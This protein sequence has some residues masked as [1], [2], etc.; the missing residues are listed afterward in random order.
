MVFDY[1]LLGL[2]WMAYL[3]IHSALATSR[4]KNWVAHKAPALAPWYRLLYN[5]V[6]LIGLA[7]LWFWMQQLPGSRLW[8]HP[9]LSMLSAAFLLAGGWLGWA[10]FRGYHFGDFAG[11]R[12]TPPGFNEHRTLSTGGLNRYVRHP[13]YSATILL[14]LGWLMIAGNRSTLTA[15]AAILVYLPIGIYWEEQKLL[16]AYGEAYREYARKVKKVIP[17]VW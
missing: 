16:K 13:L 7:V 9:W 4:A 6:A 15:V 1:G 14:V 11:L 10:S 2:G 17:G 5:T 3:L 12:S 8:S